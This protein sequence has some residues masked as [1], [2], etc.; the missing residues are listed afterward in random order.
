MPSIWFGLFCLGLLLILQRRW[1]FNQLRARMPPGPPGGLLGDNRLDISRKAPWKTFKQWNDLYGPVA[2]FFLGSRPTIVLGTVEAATDLL[3]K[4]GDIYSSRPPN[5]LVNDVYTHGMRGIGMPYG[6][7]WRR[8]RTLQQ[9]ALSIQGSANYRPLQTLESSIFLKDVLGAKDS[10][11]I[12]SYMKRSSLFTVYGHQATQFT[13]RFA[14]SVT[15]CVAYGRRIERLD[16][17]FVVANQQVESFFLKLTMP[18]QIVDLVRNMSPPMSSSS[19]PNERYHSSP[20]SGIYQWLDFQ[21]KR[22]LQWFR[23]EVD[24]QREYAT[25][26]F[27]TALEAVKSQIAQDTAQPS[28]ATHA[29]QKQEEFGM[30]DTEIAYALSAPWSAGVSTTLAAIEVAILAM[31]YN[32]DVMRKAQA[33]LDRAV[34]RTRIPDFR[35]FDALPYLQAVIKEA[36]R[37][38][39]IA[40]VGFPH[41]VIQDD[42]YK[43]M[44]IPKGSTVI[45]NIHTI[46]SDPAV[47]P[48]PDLFKPERF[49]ESSDPRLTNYNLSF[50]FGRR[51]CPG[52]H[53]A[54]QSMFIVL[55]R[56]LGAFDIV[57]V[58]GMDGKPDIQPSDDFTP[59]IVSRPANLKYRLTLRHHGAQELIMLECERAETELSAWTS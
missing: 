7:K 55:A 49:L 43:G 18:G 5:K 22:P 40:H 54:Q 23:Y 33:E 36:L 29:L 2:S 48:D 32:P 11:E 12:Q 19:T 9:S 58:L 17:N 57:P 45:A 50:G 52:M 35:D 6:Q 30:N 44:F 16:D 28:M 41:A 46:T 34:G 27:T 8:W 39:P 3:E 51:I 26:V 47:F 37:W 21:F 42:E 1:K 38:R 15:I 53:I 20:S 25:R 56:I 14:I 31:L 13:L 10:E 24:R 59:G 4:R